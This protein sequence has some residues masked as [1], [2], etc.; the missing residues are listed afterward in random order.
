MSIFSPR[1]IDSVGFIYVISI[2]DPLF[3]KIGFT[4]DTKKRHEAYLCHNPLAPQFAHVEQGTVAIEKRAQKLCR[5][6]LALTGDMR[7]NEWY[8]NLTVD[9]AIAAVR[10][11]KRQLKREAKAAAAAAAP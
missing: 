6:R 4:T 1:T 9:D 5:Q 11:A 10:D 8:Q 7:R 3:T 2:V